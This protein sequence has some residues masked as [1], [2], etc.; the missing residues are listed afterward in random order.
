ML[1]WLYVCTSS[2]RRLRNAETGLLSDLS[3]STPARLKPYRHLYTHIIHI[4]Q[5]GHLDPEV[6]A[7]FVGTVVCCGHVDM[8]QHQP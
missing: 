8:S 4:V 3:K 5:I 7:V 2:C 1:A 6:I